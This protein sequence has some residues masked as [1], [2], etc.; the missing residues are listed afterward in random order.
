MSSDYFWS[1][2]EQAQQRLAGSVVLY[3]DKPVYIDRVERH[4]DGHPRGLL[5]FI[6]GPEEFVRKKLNSPHFG[7]FREMPRL[8]WFNPASGTVKGGALFMARRATAGQKHGLVSNNITVKNFGYN[9]VCR[10][11]TGNYSFS[12]V[13]FN[14]GWVNAHNNEFPALD[15]ILQQIA[16][17]S[18]IAFSRK[19]CVVRD[20]D[21]LRWLYHNDT[22]V[23]VFTGADTLSII[24]RYNY[25]REEI[26]AE[27]SFTLNTIREF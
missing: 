21:G 1:D 27:K 15:A 8:G 10:L 12:S 4:D 16:E 9:E 7:R 18:A 14:K 25:L 22:R 6:D 26:M 11:Q 20:S 3:D 24:S 13:I 5:R 17:N 2:I 19:F 23:G